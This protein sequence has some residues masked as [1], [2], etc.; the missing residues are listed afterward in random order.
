MMGCGGMMVVAGVFW[1]LVLAA[2]VLGVVFLIRSLSGGG[3]RFGGDPALRALE[4][5]Y[6]RGDIDERELRERRDV[7]RGGHER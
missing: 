7:L 2:L 4:E 1:L 6:A 5:R 3:F